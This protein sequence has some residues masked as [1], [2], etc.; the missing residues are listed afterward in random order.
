MV[1]IQA[2]KRG[3][4]YKDLRG[5]KFGRLK[6]I[7]D[8]GRRRG[9]VLWECKCSCGNYCQVLSAEL[10][11]PIGVRSCG[12][13]QKEAFSKLKA[14]DLTN[15]KFH[16]LLVVEK[17][18]KRSR[19]QIVWICR[20]DCGNIKAVISGDLTSGHTKSCGCLQKEKAK[21]NAKKLGLSMRGYKS[22]NW[23]GGKS[24]YSSIMWNEDF[25]KSIRKRDFCKCQICETKNRI[26]DIHHIDLNKS[27]SVHKNL[28]TLC[29]SCH[30]KVHHGLPIA[31]PV[32]FKVKGGN[33]V[34][35]YL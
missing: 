31:Q 20:C 18:E 35:I 17:T 9:N 11:R 13:L 28:I 4:R 29:R 5:L 7:R 27:N 23:R 12:C 25:L 21:I 34:P 33:N 1:D 3:C 22:P 2:D 24:K 16:R 30:K 6:V 8:V 19:G 15:K 10:L 14:L 32:N 26:L